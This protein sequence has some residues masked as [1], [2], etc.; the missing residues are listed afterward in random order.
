[1]VEYSDSEFKKKL[2]FLTVSQKAIQSLSTWCLERHEHYKSI[3]TIWLNTIKKVKIKKRLLLF[4]LANHVIQYS[5]RQNY[6]FV[7]RWKIAIQKA[8][9]Y[10]R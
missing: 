10:V 7:D 4:Y 8:I 6:K 3:I 1:M 5:K 9:P 2:K